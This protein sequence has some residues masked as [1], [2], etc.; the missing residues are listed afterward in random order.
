MLYGFG[1]S[2][3]KRPQATASDRK[4]M[5]NIYERGIDL[6]RL[7]K[8]EREILEELKDNGYKMMMSPTEVAHAWRRSRADQGRALMEGFTEFRNGKYILYRRS[9]VAKQIARSR[10]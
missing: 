7:S 10:S 5:L 2:R 3:T 8:L 1:L 9:D 4:Q 6:A